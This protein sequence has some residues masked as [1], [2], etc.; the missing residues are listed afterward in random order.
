MCNNDGRGKFYNREEGEMND[1]ETPHTAF[2]IGFPRLPFCCDLRAFSASFMQIR[3][4]TSPI[5]INWEK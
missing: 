1:R 4:F 3:I 5:R 2:T